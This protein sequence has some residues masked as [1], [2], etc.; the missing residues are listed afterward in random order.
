MSIALTSPTTVNSRRPTLSGTAP[1]NAIVQVYHAGGSIHYGTAYA[2][3]SGHWQL[4][5]SIDLVTDANN[6]VDIAFAQFDPQGQQISAWAG[7]VLNVNGTGGGTALPYGSPPVLN[8]PNNVTSLRPTLTGTAPR[9][10]YIGVYSSGGATL[11]GFTYAND[12]GQWTLTPTTNLVTDASNQANIA[13]A[14][15]N[16]GG[17]QIS[18]WASATL[19][20]SG[21]GGGATPTPGSAPTLTSPTNINTYRPT[22]TGSAPPNST[23]MVYAPGGATL[24]GSAYV[25]S[26]GSWS[27]TPTTNLITDTNGKADIAFAV[28]NQAN[29]QVSAWASASLYVSGTGGGVALPPGSAPVLTSSTTVNSVRPTLVGRAAPNAW[30]RVFHQG[31][32]PEYGSTYAGPDGGWT[33]TPSINLQPDNNRNVPLGIAEFGAG[34]DQRSAWTAVTLAVI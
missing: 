12:S 16:P 3:V 18:A 27:L 15:F 21:I 13:F 31:G 10:A 29:Q 28:F 5:P 33:F 8:S 30:V 2:D 6:N 7:A 23:V 34:G 4:T 22:L 25:N 14:V 17:G 20:V 1:S 32:S 11:Y 9:N 19:Y 24:Y 26:N